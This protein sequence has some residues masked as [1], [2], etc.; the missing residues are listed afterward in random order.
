MVME[1][2]SP[3]CVGREFVRQYYTLLHEAP[4]Y[5]HR[6]YSHNSSF[7]H[8]GVEKPG[9]EQP[10]VMGQGEIHKKIMSLNFRDCHAKIRQVDSQATVGS[11]VV[12][13]VT[14]ELSNNGEPMRRFMQT[15]VLAP[16][17]PKKYYVHNDI[18]RY[19]D[20]VFHDDDNDPDNLEENGESETDT[21]DAAVLP[22]N[23]Q[24]PTVTTSFFDTAPSPQPMSNGSVHMEDQVES[25]TEEPVEEDV[26]E[27][28]PPQDEDFEVDNS[29][30]STE[31]EAETE[32][33]AFPV[34]TK[35][36]SWAALASKN[37][38]SGGSGVAASGGGPAKVPP[39]KME[40][41]LEGPPGG[42]PQPQRGPRSAPDNMR[43]QRDR[44]DRGD[45]P[46]RPEDADPERGSRPSSRYPDNQQLFV[47]N[48]PH[49]IEQKDLRAYFDT[50]GKVLELRI[51]TKNTGA[52]KTPGFGFVVFESSE[53]VQKILSE[54]PI[55]YKGEHRL[56][57][58]EK[59]SGRPGSNPR[60][61]VGRGDRLGGGGRGAGPLP[62][63]GG[64]R[65]GGG[66]SASRP[67]NR[68]GRGGSFGGPRR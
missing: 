10:P 12:V 3:Q 27:E 38:S 19:Q 7:V 54:K 8:G 9:E 58:E 46:P 35:P 55:M 20:E 43:P 62:G 11:A 60:S 44:R 6:F 29:P 16:Q 14:G 50:F 41:K 26:P 63:R 52:S 64:G 22:E 45:R 13:Q 28:V 67:D 42:P 66:S 40:P 18:F 36:F 31:A 49:N 34:E 59:K 37:T 47:G 1:T 23:V 2:P 4:S 65:G 57:V 61:S 33:P 56:N 39:V 21:N 30:K 5:L 32:Q 68:G 51:N 24:D 53:P 48:L 15:F 25:P 17:S